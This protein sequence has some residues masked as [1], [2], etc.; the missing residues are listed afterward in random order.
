MIKVIIDRF[1]GDIAVCEQI[2]LTSIYIKKDDL[3]ETAKPGSILKIYENGPITL[4][5]EEEAKRRKRIK[6]IYKKIFNRK[7]D[8]K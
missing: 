4:D 3:P 6:D 1:E 5:K 7:I 8:K 2:D